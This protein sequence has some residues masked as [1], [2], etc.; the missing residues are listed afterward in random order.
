[1]DTLDQECQKDKVQVY[2]NVPGSGPP[3]RYEAKSLGVN[4]TW[5]SSQG[6][7]SR[8]EGADDP[9]VSG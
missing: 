4:S 5:E 3:L 2:N 1:M 7:L 9:G 8:K 6:L